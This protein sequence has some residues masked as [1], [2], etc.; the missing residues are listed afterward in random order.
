MLNHVSKSGPWKFH[1]WAA[2]N[3][4]ETLCVT[5]LLSICAIY[6]CDTYTHYGDVIISAVASQITCVWMVC[7]TICS[8]ADQR[9]HQSSVSL[10]FAREIHQW[11]VNSGWIP[12]AR[13]SSA[14]NVSIWR[15]RH[16]RMPVNTIL[17]YLKQH[18]L[19]TL[20]TN[21]SNIYYALY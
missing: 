13:A 5:V 14:E 21:S 1:P 3:V 18:L 10:A 8:G 9:K 7:S 20:Y 17:M 19:L 11:P 4:H 2:T 6:V 12:F 15:R 16:E